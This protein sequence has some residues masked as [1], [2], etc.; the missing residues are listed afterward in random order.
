MAIWA[1]APRASLI[2]RRLAAAVEPPHQADPEAP[3]DGDR[4]D[5]LDGRPADPPGRGPGRPRRWRRQQQRRLTG[6]QALADGADEQVAGH[7][8]EGR[9]RRHGPQLVGPQRPHRV[10]RQQSEP[11]VGPGELADE[12]AEERRRCGDL[13]PGEQVGHARPGAHGHERAHESPPVAGHEVRPRLGDGP[14]PDDHRHERRVEDGQRGERDLRAVARAVH[15]AQQRAHRHEREA[16]HRQRDAQHD[17]LRQRHDGDDRR[18]H[19]G[20][21]VA[22]H[23]APRR[24]PQRGARRPLVQR[25]VVADGGGDAGRRGDDVGAGERRAG[26]DLPQHEDDHE[27]GRGATEVADV[28]AAGGRWRRRGGRLGGH[29][30][31]HGVTWGGRRRRRAASRPRPRGRGSRPRGGG[32][33]GAAA[34]WGSPPSPRCARA[35][36]S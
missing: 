25:P 34:R 28:H 1:V 26:Q 27:P 30:Q 33:P 18:Q 9:D 11:S 35:G 7:R 10:D 20:R 12:R 29:D 24:L 21:Q 32:G 5:D 31:C 3:Q 19:D 13:Q 36:A 15:D 14:Q 8:H 22:P 2:S 23:E 17:P 16:E 4:D 6:R